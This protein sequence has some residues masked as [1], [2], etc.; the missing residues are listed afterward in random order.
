MIF[1]FFFILGLL[2]F[3]TPSREHG[4]CNR[5]KDQ[6]LLAFVH[7]PFVLRCASLLACL[8]YSHDSSV[9]YLPCLLLSLS[10][11]SALTRTTTRSKATQASSSGIRPVKRSSTLACLY[12]V[13]RLLLVHLTGLNKSENVSCPFADLPRLGLQF[14]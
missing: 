10:R 4:Q 6:Y 2:C 12:W 11:P 5:S 3:L 8:P 9:R 14:L 1:V 7:C 13:S